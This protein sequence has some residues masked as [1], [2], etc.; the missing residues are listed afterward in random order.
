MVVSEWG[1]LWCLEVDD[2]QHSHK[3]ITTTLTDYSIKPDMRDKQC[4]SKESNSQ[5]QTKAKSFPHNKK[6]P[7][8]HCNVL[9]TQQHI[10]EKSITWIII[11]YVYES[12][13]NPKWL[14]VSDRCKSFTIVT[15]VINHKHWLTPVLFD[16]RDISNQ[17]LIYIWQFSGLVQETYR[18][19]RTNQDT[20]LGF[21]DFPA[22]HETVSVHE[23]DVT[24][25][26]TVRVV[27]TLRKFN[28]MRLLKRTVH[29]KMNSVIILYEFLFSVDHNTYFE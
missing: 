22:P 11:L 21:S 26:T 20:Y 9:E 10:N 6:Q 5:F 7:R 19:L 1:W 15:K 28:K 14:T 16:L 29:P 4:S 12:F 8:S 2:V 17:K 24:A 25:L 23:N 3:E 13:V 18:N 27:Y